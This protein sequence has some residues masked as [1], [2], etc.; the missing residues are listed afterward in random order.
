MCSAPCSFGERWSKA[1][2]PRMP[3]DD[4]HADAAAH[5]RAGVQS[6]VAAAPNLDQLRYALNILGNGSDGRHDAQTWV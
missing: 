6:L 5:V 3:A 4:I 1:R 2:V